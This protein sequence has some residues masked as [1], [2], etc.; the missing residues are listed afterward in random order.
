MGEG[1]E[2]ADFMKIMKAPKS[3]T[4]VPIPNQGTPGAT[5]DFF[6]EIE[7]NGQGKSYRLPVRMKDLADEGVILELPALPP[8]LE[9]EAILH[10]EGTIYLA[11]DG[12]S[13]EI[14]LRS[15][16]VWV[17]QQD[18]GSPYLLGL[19]LGEADF[20]ARR[21]LENLIARPKD[22]SDLWTYWD[23]S[24]TKPA[25]NNGRITFYIGAGVLVGGLALKIALPDSY[26]A[27]AIIIALLGSYVIAGTCLWHWW[28]R[29]SIPKES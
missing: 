24:Q 22:M 4:S 9:S 21:S 6:L 12:F 7:P 27:M 20:R 29:R 10:Q 26:S 2:E 8:G 25:G 16:V 18:S 19:D 14:Q 13:K 15:K 23:Q 1:A 5:S 28:R 11:P 17:R 3:P